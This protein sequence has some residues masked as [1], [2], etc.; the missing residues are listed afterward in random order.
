MRSR[1]ADRRPYGVFL[2]TTLL[3]GGFSSVLRSVAEKRRP[4]GETSPVCSGE[5]DSAIEARFLPDSAAQ[6]RK[7]AGSAAPDGLPSGR[8]T[9]CAAVLPKQCAVRKKKRREANR[10]LPLSPPRAFGRLRSQTKVRNNPKKTGRT[11]QPPHVRFLT[12]TECRASGLFFY[13][14]RINGAKPAYSS[15]SASFALPVSGSYRYW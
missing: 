11:A 8:R 9:D 10:S 6:R 14:F 5:M 15:A 2:I 3:I 13:L 1:A 12:C 7:T 4:A